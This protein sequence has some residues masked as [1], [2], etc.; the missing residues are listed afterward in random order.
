MQDHNDSEN[1]GANLLD[2]SKAG[3][4]K[5]SSPEGQGSGSGVTPPWLCQKLPE[6]TANTVLD[7]LL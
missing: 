4:W 6:S 3:Q 5:E 2:M 7:N 1:I